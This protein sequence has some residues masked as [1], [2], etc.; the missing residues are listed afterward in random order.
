MGECGAVRVSS[1]PPEELERRKCEA[2][3]RLA[4]RERFSVPA[5]TRRNMTVEEWGKWCGLFA[6]WDTF[7]T[8][9]WRP[10]YAKWSGK[11]ALNDCLRY[12]TEVGYAGA[13]F[14]S[15]E[16]TDRANPFHVH[17][18]LCG[19]QLAAA[20]GAKSVKAGHGA[21]WRSWFAG[22]GYAQV[23]ELAGNGAVYYCSK[24]V[25][26]SRSALVLGDTSLSRPVETI[27]F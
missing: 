13:L 25:L 3:K 12:L 8:L 27:L 23:G 9:T 2:A 6:P 20:F 7:I 26:K 19:D 14:L 22:R 1:L 24:Y 4:D 5:S 16:S 15:A 10:E 11:S 21:L 17:G 18:L